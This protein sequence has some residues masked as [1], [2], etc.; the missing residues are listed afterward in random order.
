MEASSA[1]KKQDHK[2]SKVDQHG[3]CLRHP[4]AGEATGRAEHGS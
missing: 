4:A 2:N 3:D 1:N